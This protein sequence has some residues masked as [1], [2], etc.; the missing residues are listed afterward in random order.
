MLLTNNGWRSTKRSLGYRLA[1][2]NHYILRSAESFLVKRDRGRINHTEHDQG[3]D[4]WMRRNYA[5]ETDD[6]IHAR[7]PMMQKVLDDF[8]KDKTLSKLHKDAVKWHE[9][10]IKKLLKDA[11]YKQ[12][13]DDLTKTKRKDALDISKE[14]EAEEQAQLEQAQAE[15]D[16]EKPPMDYVPAARLK[17]MRLVK[18][19]ESAAKSALH[20]RF[21]D[22]RNFANRSQGFLWEGEDN[23]LMFAPRSKRLVVTFDNLTIAREEGQRWPWG[24]K[25]LFEDLGCSVL[26]VMAVNRNWFRHDFVHDSFEAL[27]DQK[28]FD[29]FDDILFYG[30]SMGGYGALVYQAC[31]PGSNVLAIAPQTTLD[32]AIVPNEERWGWTKKLDWDGRFNDGAAQTDLARQITIIADP[33]FE[34]DYDQVSRIKSDNVTWLKTPFMGHQLPNAFHVMG[35]LKDILVAGTGGTLTPELFYKL[36]RAR[37]DLPRFQHD[38]LMEAERRGKLKSAIQICEY[39]LKK[40][41][42]QNI[43]RSL[44]RL[45]EELA[46][47]SKEAAE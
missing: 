11:D 26:G 14:A 42:A 9:G 12:L 40:R 18:A 33:Y 21:E 24:M 47:Q 3:I 6:R 29:Q 36:F 2:L 31:A 44:D 34:P 46:A 10:K 20:D 37:R 22:A 1:T 19:P 15:R 32:R 38:L 45:K 39:T 25:P 7:L 8:Q 23:A 28:F 43:K 17:S 35:I 16:A 41:K 4:Y 27:R 13:F 30:T 5:S